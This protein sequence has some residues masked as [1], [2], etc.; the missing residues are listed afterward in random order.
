[1]TAHKTLF[2]A[3][4][5]AHLCACSGGDGQ[6]GAQAAPVPSAAKHM[7]KP[8]DD[9]GKVPV[10]AAKP[11]AYR[12]MGRRDPFRSYMLDAAARRQAERGQRHLEET[13]SFELSQY[14]LT[15]VLTG[16]SQPKAMVEDPS[17]KAH[18]VRIGTRL[19]RAGGRVS[20]IDSKSLTVLEE[21]IDPQGQPLQVPVSLKLPSQDNDNQGQD[22]GVPL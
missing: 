21:S 19:G 4:F 20:S 11:F 15:G 10:P 6:T 1:M 3:L 13:E 9:K 5:L 18:V 2:T 22:P 16:T 7:A 17:G 8:L 12:S 14:N